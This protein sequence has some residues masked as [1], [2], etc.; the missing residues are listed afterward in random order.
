[1]G[2][3]VYVDKDEQEISFTHF[4]NLLRQKMC[5]IHRYSHLLLSAFQVCTENKIILTLSVATRAQLVEPIYLCHTEKP[6]KVH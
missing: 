5:T 1:M 4:C 6:S 2:V 3:Q